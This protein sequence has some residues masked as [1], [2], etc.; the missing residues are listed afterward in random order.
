M[1]CTSGSH[2]RVLGP[3]FTLNGGLNATEHVVQYIGHVRMA[4][5]PARENETV[6]NGEMEWILGWVT[7]RRGIVELLVE[8]GAGN[9]G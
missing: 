2:L 3:L 7:L 8:V 5:R 6:L 9:V 1:V 4:Q